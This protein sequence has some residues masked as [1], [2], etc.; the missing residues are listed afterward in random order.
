[1]SK[2]KQKH[3]PVLG[4]KIEMNRAPCRSFESVNGPS[5]W[6]DART[7]GPFSDAGGGIV[8][9]KIADYDYKVRA[10]IGDFSEWVALYRGK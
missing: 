3:E 7:V 2:Q 10:G 4:T 8:A 5:I 1:M 9:F 6:V